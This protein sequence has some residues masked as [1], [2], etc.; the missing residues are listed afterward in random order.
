MKPMTTLEL[1]ARKEKCQVLSTV[2]QLPIAD[3]Q[4]FKEFNASLSIQLWHLK[5]VLSYTHGVLRTFIADFVDCG[6]LTVFEA[7][8]VII[9]AMVSERLPSTSDSYTGGIT[10]GY[11]SRS[12][13]ENETDMMTICQVGEIYAKKERTRM[14]RKPLTC[15]CSTPCM[16]CVKRAL[17][18]Y[19]SAVEMETHSFSRYKPLG[20]WISSHSDMM[21]YFTRMCTCSLPLCTR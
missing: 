19:R 8:R 17:R 3:P 1:K 9:V 13:I 4:C 18:P 6:V 11:S 7:M 21:T 15:S 16:R 10:A 12:V 14:A 20:G 2:V 5:I